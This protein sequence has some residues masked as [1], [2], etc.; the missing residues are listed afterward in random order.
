MR[1]SIR[2]KILAVTGLL[3]LLAVGFYTLLASFI[4]V[5]Q[6]TALLYE[7]NHSVS[8][9]SASQIRSALQQVA[10]T[11]K[12]YA[13][14]RLLSS[15]AALRLPA[16]GLKDSHI[17]ALAF[18]EKIGEEFRPLTLP[19][20]L[21]A[22]P[23]PVS[24]VQNSLKQALTD[25]FALWVGTSPA[26]TRPFFLAARL[27]IEQ[28]KTNRVFVSIA[29]LE[30]KP[31]IESLLAAS[32]FESF[33][34]T[35]DG[36]V[37]VH[38]KDQSEVDSE[39]ISD[40]PLIQNS[41]QKANLSGVLSYPYGGKQRYGAY[42][43]VGIG[44]LLFISQADESEVQSAL[45]VLLQRSGL[46]GLIVITLTFIASVL[47]SKT[48]TRNLQNLTQGVVAIGGGNLNSHIH[49]KS[50]DEVEALAG[51]FNQMVDALR[52]SREAIE[53]YNHELE[54]K[55]ALRTK[56][57]SETNA[58]IKAVQEKLVQTSQLAAVGEV[59]G[60]TAHELLNPLT[61]ILS[62]IER[63]RSSVKA[64]SQDPTL[65]AQILE[66]LNA[67]KAEYSEGGLE[68]L[69][70]SLSQ[71]SKVQAGKT[72][73]DEDLA[74]LEE[75]AGYWQSQSSVVSGDLDFVRDQAERI[76][77]I[78]DKMRELIRSSDKSHVACRQAVEE[79]VA[80]MKDFLSKHQVTLELTWEANSDNA[81]LN[82]DELIQI[83]TNLVRNAYQAI[84][85]TQKAGRIQVRAFNT[86]EA[87]IVEVADN[88]TGISEENQKRLFDQGFT[89][90]GPSEGTGLGLSI[91]RRYARAFGGD[92]TLR[93]SSAEQGTCF[94][95][96]IP[97]S[98]QN[99]AAA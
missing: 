49:V 47:F 12:L 30:R 83:V 44:G 11:L 16:S 98:E 1:L 43:P 91:C 32:V 74:N 65:P 57:L 96:S 28:G 89:T 71:P 52:A 31:L 72:L 67:W 46:F 54:D 15:Q 26:G 33:L 77:R 92:V 19:P 29:Q 82:R 73:L 6:K 61:A 56:Q 20:D 39:S 40:H 90:K 36:K 42:A 79:A 37:L 14:S 8:V 9:N 84:Q 93:Y 66:I 85:T 45:T 60:R 76:H 50:G 23:L 87:L 97:L 62:R 38:L 4:F 25:R 58:T 64:P 75:L 68:K 88:G 95:I 53:K 27:E 22:L 24:Q 80:T 51:S 35:S 2:Y 78:V 70:Q 34:S 3:L 5:E 17:E 10:E 94:Q 81:E 59:A 13:V 99:E 55:V 41:L 48:L 63:S 69:L 18:F 86:S 7:I 21:P